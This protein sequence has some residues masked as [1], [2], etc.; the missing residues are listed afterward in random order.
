MRLAFR[1]EQPCGICLADRPQLL[2]AEDRLLEFQQRRLETVKRRM[3]TEAEPRRAA[4][5][6]SNRSTPATPS[7][8]AISRY[9][10]PP[11]ESATSGSTPSGARVLSKTS[12]SPGVCFTSSRQRRRGPPPAPAADG[13][14]IRSSSMH[15]ASCTI[16]RSLDGQPEQPGKGR[17]VEL[18]AVIVR[19]QADARHVVLAGRSAAG[20]LPSR[21]ASD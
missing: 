8:M 15:S 18:V 14:I 7:S 6:A 12:R 21:A 19:V 20:L 17:I 16:R 4:R 13:F 2:I 3:R 11:A 9:T 1:H 5:A 10:S